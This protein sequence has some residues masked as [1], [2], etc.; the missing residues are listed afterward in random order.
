V[1]RLGAGVL[2]ALGGL[3]LG[4]AVAARPAIGQRIKLSASLSDL[5]ARARTDSN[6]AAAHYNVALA[7][8]NA[9]RWDDAG[10]A[11]TL[12]VTIDPRFAQAYLALSRLPYARRGALWDEVEQGRVPKELVDTV[13]AS[14]RFYRRAYLIDPLVDMKIEGA[15]APPRSVYWDLFDPERYDL[16]FRGFDDLREGK[17]TDALDR[18]ER[19]LGLF[20]RDRNDEGL[21]AGLLWYR[22]V[23]AAHVEKYD[24]AQR[25]LQ[26]LLARAEHQERSDSLI[27]VPLRTNE[28]RYVLAYLKHRGGDANGAIS[29][30]RE[31]LENDVGLY[32]A[33]VRLAEIYESA[34]RWDQA[35]AHRQNAVNANPDDP[36]LLLDLGRTLASAGRL[37]EALDPLRQAADANPRDSRVYF[38][39]GLVLE[40]T[41]K[42]DEARAA[43][44]RFTSLAPS[45]YDRQISIAK[46]HLA[47]FQ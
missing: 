37:T 30:Y 2:L 38:Y 45:R 36:S 4:V 13:N 31:A 27:R 14:D 23:A 43:L 20:R 25:D 16:L 33:H 46:Q 42:K 15:V 34:Q 29:L 11:L 44:T 6:D 41:G 32:M 3:C 40:Q 47:A 18:L 22:A 28:F 7:Y 12:A 9:K 19:L 10:R 21:P 26:E 1:T 8:W 24:Q 17:Y 35:I 39:L 5:E